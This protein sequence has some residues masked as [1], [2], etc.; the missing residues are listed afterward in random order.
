MLGGNEPFTEEQEVR[1]R[2]IVREQIEARLGPPMTAARLAQIRDEVA[3]EH[4]VVTF[5]PLDSTKPTRVLKGEAGQ[6]AVVPITS[7]C[8]GLQ[9]ELRSSPRCVPGTAQA[10]RRSRRGLSCLLRRLL[11]RSGQSDA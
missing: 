11:G 10:R 8:D 5:I 3:R 9:A 4:H 6:E 1:L 7:G 2:E